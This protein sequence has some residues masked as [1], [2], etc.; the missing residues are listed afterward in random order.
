[1]FTS[2]ESRLMV[3]MCLFFS[4]VLHR[5]EIFQNLEQ[6]GQESFKIEEFNSVFPWQP[7]LE[8]EWNNKSKSKQTQKEKGSGA[9]IF[10]A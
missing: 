4:N 10:T 6:K 7:G 5:F 9:A 1:M 8:D 2:G 3:Y